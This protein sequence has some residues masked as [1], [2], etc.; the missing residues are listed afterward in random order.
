MK[1]DG[2]LWHFAE[3]LYGHGEV[4]KACLFLQD[5]CGVDVNVLLFALWIARRKVLLDA[6]AVSE[7]DAAVKQWRQEI[8]VPLRAVRR[9]MKTGPSPAPDD[10][11]EALRSRLQEI[12]IESERIELS[13]L[14]AI[15]LGPLPQ[16]DETPIAKN[17]LAV[18]GAYGGNTADP[19]VTQAIAAIAAAVEVS[20]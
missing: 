17:V 13:V 15:D 5:Q 8:V 2:S 3:A 14:E 7:I 12:E 10:T 9:R 19:L 6:A 20:A 18:V 16:I 4:S 11:T 1:T